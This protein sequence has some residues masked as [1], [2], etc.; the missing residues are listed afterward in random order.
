MSYF[1]DRIEEY[2]RM[3]DNYEPDDELT[4]AI[5]KDDVDTVQKLLSKSEASLNKSNVPFNIFE[6]YILNGE[7]KYINYA[8][9]YGS[10]KCFKYFLL[11]HYEIDST[12]FAHAVMGGNIEIIK[13]VYQNEPSENS[14]VVVD[15]NVRQINLK[16][17]FSGK[18]NQIMPAI[19]KHRNDLFDWIFEQKFTDKDLG[20]SLSS[21]IYRSIKNGHAHSLIEIIDK[22][23]NLTDNK[24]IIYYVQLAAQR[25]FYML[26]QLI[27]NITNQTINL[28]KYSPGEIRYKDIIKFENIS[29]FHLFNKSMN[30]AAFESCL[31]NAIEND[32]R[33]IIKSIFENFIKEEKEPVLINLV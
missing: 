9:V 29:I 24:D 21:L 13:I 16:Q 7:T 8:A 4:N 14:N 25:G 6:T 5:R 22:G 32:S 17:Y 27:L 23:F 12:T 20:N 19:M 26:A 3:R 33:C 18:I 2:K 11:N 30:R 1:P 31:N 10:I 28:N 15:F